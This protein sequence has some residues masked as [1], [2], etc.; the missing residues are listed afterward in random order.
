MKRA[1]FPRALRAYY[2]HRVAAAAVSTMATE[3]RKRAKS[4]HRDISSFFVKKSRTLTVSIL[5]W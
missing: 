2:T 1:L 5:F 3:G 4:Y